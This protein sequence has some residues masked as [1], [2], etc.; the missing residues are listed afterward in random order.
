MISACG[1]TSK[2]TFIEGELSDIYISPIDYREMK[3]IPSGQFEMGN[4]DTDS[5]DPD[6]LPVHTV[7][8]EAFY[9]DIHEVTNSQ[10]QQFVISTGYSTPPLWHDSKFNKPDSPVVNVSWND[11][12][13]YAN[14]AK[15]RLPTEAEWEYAARGGLIGKVYSTSNII[16]HEDANFGGIE[17]KDIWKWTAP[18]GSFPPNGYG[19]YD[20][21]G[22]VWEWCFDE[23]NGGFYESSP[24]HNPKFG[25]N[26]APE[27]ENFRILRG[28]GWGGSEEDLR[29]SDRWYHLSSGSTIGFRCVKDIDS[30]N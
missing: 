7:S 5:G 29:V 24:K 20:M 23:Y 22:N 30:M 19:L 3:L 1:D 9:I 27:N 2:Q 28:G 13:A 6:E 4:S 11:A 18:V 21:I 12:V 16:T 15:K 26:K 8:L 10:Y 25:R 14:W 17:G